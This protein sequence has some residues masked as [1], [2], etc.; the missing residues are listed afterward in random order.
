MNV[1]SFILRQGEGMDCF[2]N[3]NNDD[4]D[5]TREFFNDPS[6]TLSEKKT[7]LLKLIEVNKATI[8]ILRKE[9]ER[10]VHDKVLSSLI[11]HLEHHIQ[12]CE[13]N[14]ENLKKFS[15]DYLTTES[16]STQQQQ[17]QL[18]RQISAIV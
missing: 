14:V 2:L 9:I 13:T 10:I 17:L 16:D 3:N 12:C 6:I 7:H 5:K 1:R 15:D 11:C 4:G 18:E 8:E